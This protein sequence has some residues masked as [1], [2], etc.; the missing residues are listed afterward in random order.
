[1]KIDFKKIIAELQQTTPS[2]K[3]KTS[4]YVT[5]STWERFK[6]ACGDIP[7]SGM[8][9]KLMEQYLAWVD[10]QTKDKD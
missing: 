4:L 6:E 9:E 8:I 5:S 1:V 7:P 2:N 3:I 10:L